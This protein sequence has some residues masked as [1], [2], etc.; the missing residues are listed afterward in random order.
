MPWIRRTKPMFNIQEELDKLPHKPGVYLMHDK[1]DNIIYVGK[2]KILYNRV[3]SYFRESTKKTLKIQRM[4][5]LIDHFEYIIVDSELEAL[6]L[7]NNLIKEYNPKYNT[8]LKD[9]KT[10]PYI[11]V[12]VNE[13]YPRIFMVRNT[14]RD[15]AKYFGPFTSAQAVNDIIELLNATF[16]LRSCQKKCSFGT[17]IDRQCLNYH[18]KRCLGPCSGNVPVPEYMEGI[19]KALDFLNGNDKTILKELKEKMDQ[20]SERLDFEE[21]IKYRELYDSAA[22]IIERQKITDTDE[23]DRDI[24]GIATDDTDAV[25]QVFFIRDGKM[26]GREHHHIGEIEGEEAASVLSEFIKRYY[27]GTPYVPSAIML[28]FEIEEASEIEEWLSYVKG[29][30][31]KLLIPKVGTKER[32]VELAN[33][34]AALVLSQD[35]EKIIKEEKHTK[36]AAKE[37]ADLIGLQK[38]GRIEAYDISNT[39]GFENV[40]SMVVF[41]EGKPVKG[42]Y[43]KF[44]IKSVEGP[45]DYACMYEVLTRRFKHGFEEKKRLD[46]EDLPEAYGSF[47][48]FPDLLLM[49]GGKGQVNICK[50]VL[51]EMN[52]DIPVCGMVKDDYHNTRGL[53]VE[54]KEIDI[55]KNSEAFK[56]ITRI[57]DEAHRFA[58]EYHKSLRSKSLTHSVLDDIKDIGPKRKRALMRSFNSIEDIRKAS[59]EELLK[60]DGMSPAAAESVYK[61]FRKGLE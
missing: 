51:S 57:Q 27:T 6:V 53:Y 42:D 34:N 23:E 8:L 56:L 47:A 61:F 17:S 41:E 28:P 4:V 1:D 12:S 32:L 45:N 21:A 40:G 13:E 26:I 52:I 37:L 9:S 22:R 2:A 24:I 16:K 20:A 7:E 58:I 33:S 46:K 39:N 14:H 50:R 3:R 36:G 29:R 31:V 43:R 59:V 18:M 35:K 5:S 60:I 54:G 15:K 30:K 48:R 25:V 38:A 19:K 11:K 55:D 10:Y 49:D 44:K